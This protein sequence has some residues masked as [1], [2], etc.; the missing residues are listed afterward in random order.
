MDNSRNADWINWLRQRPPAVRSVAERFP[1]W[2]DYRVKPTGQ[3][4]HISSYSEHDDGTVSLKIDVIHPVPVGV[5]GVP[6]D[7]LEAITDEGTSR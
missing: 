1:P 5:F 4:A 2:L 3:I 7:D 6:P